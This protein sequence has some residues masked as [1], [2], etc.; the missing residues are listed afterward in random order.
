M[1]F[2]RL[3]AIFVCLYSAMAH[4]ILEVTVLKQ[5]EEAFPI[6]IAPFEVVGNARQGQEIANIM[7]DNFNRSGEFNASSSKDVINAEVD[8]DKWRSQKTEAL[9]YGRIEKVNQKIFKVKV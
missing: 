4:A 7:R 2:T 8:Y 3:L 5:D 6:V 9:V 1:K